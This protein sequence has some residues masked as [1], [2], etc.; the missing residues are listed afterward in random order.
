MTKASSISD[1]TLVQSC[2]KP[3]PDS[4]Q[5][6]WVLS[7]QIPTPPASREGLT[8]M[9]FRM[10]ALKPA[11]SCRDLYRRWASRYDDRK[12]TEITASKLCPA[13]RPASRPLSRSREWPGCWNP[14]SCSEEF[15]SRELGEYPIVYISAMPSYEKAFEEA[16]TPLQR[17][18]HKT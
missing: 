14:Q 13:L 12:V 7:V 17:R 9:A 6:H 15:R 11:A 3:W 8:P 10:K 2:Q 4:P 18:G 16:A 5:V 1:S